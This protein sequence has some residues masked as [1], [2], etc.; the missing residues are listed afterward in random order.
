M[1]PSTATPTFLLFMVV[2]S[3]VGGLVALLGWT[4]SGGAIATFGV[5]TFMLHRA[6]VYQVRRTAAEKIRNMNVDLSSRA[7]RLN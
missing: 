6:C 2:A 1:G 5:V 3:F 4:T 7:D